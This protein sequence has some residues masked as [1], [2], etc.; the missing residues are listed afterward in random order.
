MYNIALDGPEKQWGYS[1]NVTRVGISYDGADFP[2]SKPEYVGADLDFVYP[3]TGKSAVMAC[4]NSP[5]LNSDGDWNAF[6]V[7]DIGDWQMQAIHHD[8]VNTLFM[9]G[10]VQSIGVASA[11]GRDEFNYAW[12]NGIPSTLANPWK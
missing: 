3:N 11:A 2:W 6:S 12:Y 10:H 5:S 4:G 1:L 8:N 9:D 7:S